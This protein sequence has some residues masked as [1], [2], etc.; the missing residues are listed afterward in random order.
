[1]SRIAIKYLL[2]GAKLL[3]IYNLWDTLTSNVVSEHAAICLRTEEWSLEVEHDTS[4]LD[5]PESLSTSKHWQITGQSEKQR[6]RVCCISF[7]SASCNWDE[8]DRILGSI[9]RRILPF[10]YNNLCAQARSRCEWAASLGFY[11][12][13]I[14][15]NKYLRIL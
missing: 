14:G 8:S 1:V 12:S 15:T 5:A 13:L 7:K 4:V 3:S 11:I 2:P 6:G 9:L 10:D